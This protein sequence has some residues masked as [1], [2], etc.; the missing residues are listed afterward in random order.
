[1]PWPPSCLRSR[2]RFEPKAAEPAANQAR[3]ECANAMTVVDLPDDARDFPAF[4]RLLLGEPEVAMYG[5]DRCGSESAPTHARYHCWF[6]EEANGGYDEC[7]ACAALPA[8]HPH[9][10]AR[11][12]DTNAA[13]RA[14]VKGATCRDSLENAFRLFADRPCIGVPSGAEIDWLTYAEL[15]YLARGLQ[16]GLRAELRVAERA[17]VGNCAEVR[18]E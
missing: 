1:M 10:L 9:R 16:L 15:H 12:T 6:C 17:K 11:E 2:K 4:T 5:C 8:V 13:L 18:L 7:A 14:R 3:K